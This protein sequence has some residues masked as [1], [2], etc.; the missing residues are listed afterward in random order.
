MAR[1]LRPTFNGQHDFYVTRAFLAHGRNFSPGELFDKQ[2]VPLRR[3]QQMYDARMLR[4]DAPPARSVL[5]KPAP[6]PSPLAA[7]LPAAK[8]GRVRLRENLADAPPS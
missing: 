5:P 6:A 1:D 7:N 2:L 3:L 4:Q 8:Q